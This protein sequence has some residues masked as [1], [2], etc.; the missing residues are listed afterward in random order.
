MIIR[1]NIELIRNNI[2][3]NL[4]IFIIIKIYDRIKSN[5]IFD[6][7]YIHCSSNITLKINGTG[8]NYIFGN[9]D[10][11][12]F[13]GFYN[14]EKVYINGKEEEKKNKYNLNETENL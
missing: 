12:I 1:Y 13:A 11:Y 14:L 8:E 2:I 4:I 5:K 7:L 3:I 9:E 6:Y 10:G